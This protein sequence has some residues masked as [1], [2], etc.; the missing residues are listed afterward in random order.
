MHCNT[1]INVDLRNEKGLFIFSLDW[2][3]F[4]MSCK[5]TFWIEKSCWANFELLQLFNVVD[6]L[7]SRLSCS[8]AMTHSMSG[9]GW[10]NFY[11]DY[12]C[13]FKETLAVSQLCP[14]F[15]VLV[16]NCPSCVQS[17]NEFFCQRWKR[18]R[19]HLSSPIL[20]LRIIFSWNKQCALVNYSRI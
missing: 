5:S 16:E 1:V 15:S 14:S 4:Q 7:I 2:N 8:K 17:W 13:R 19:F 20:K 18:N 6:T 3:S 11:V 9:V 10:M 12:L